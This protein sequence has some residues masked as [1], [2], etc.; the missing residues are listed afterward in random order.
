MDTPKSFFI[1]LTH[2]R[3]EFS[4]MPIPAGLTLPSPLSLYPSSLFTLD[5]LPQSPVDK[6]SQ[7]NGQAS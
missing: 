1:L 4:Q 6:F 3:L 5:S 2:L 7:I